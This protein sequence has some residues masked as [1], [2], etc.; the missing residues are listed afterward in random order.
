MP[1]SP[2]VRAALAA[3]C[4]LSL[5]TIAA[6]APQVPALA[7]PA[8]SDAMAL[9]RLGLEVRDDVAPH[10]VAVPA[11]AGI[12][13]DDAPGGLSGGPYVLRRLP[14]GDLF[15][16]G[17]NAWTYRGPDAL[18]LRSPRF[19]DDLGGRFG[20]ILG[21]ATSDGGFV[22]QSSQ[23]SEAL[24]GLGPALLERW[25]SPFT[26][27]EP[28]PI[29]APYTVAP[30]DHVYAFGG[31][32]SVVNGRTGAVIATIGA[33]PADE[34]VSEP[35]AAPDGGARVVTSVTETAARTL[36]R[37]ITLYRV[38]PDGTVAWSTVVAEGAGTLGVAASA[39]SVAPDGT[40]Y[41]GVATSNGI[42]RWDGRLV[43][44]GPDGAVAF[45]V[46]VGGMPSRPAIDAAGTVW[47]FTT[48]GR[49]VGVTP[50]G[51]VAFSRRLAGPGDGGSVAAHRGGVL[52]RSGALTVTMVPRPAGDAGT[53]PG[54][55]LAPSIRLQRRPFRCVAPPAGRPKTCLYRLDAALPLRI[56]APSDGT[57]D[58]TIAPVRAIL[59]D[60]GG[61]RSVPLKPARGS[62]RVL[63]GV[64]LVQLD[65]FH[66]LLSVCTPGPPCTVLP[67]D[68]R[69][70]V[71]LRAAG[72]A[73]TFARVI[74]V[75]AGTGRW[76]D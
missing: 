76:V 18:H 20:I 16:M 4:A 64:N 24:V 13:A 7:G 17:K 1:R 46:P 22:G 8:R 12:V 73:R 32:P 38:D 67:G 14:R 44:V 57:A 53:A 74:R 49:V 75:L 69:V 28:P 31:T 9:T 51:T 66:S 54:V 61:G 43:A 72:P 52:A 34:S 62:V 45:D 29:A 15:L 65:G 39:V 48:T 55:R 35:V 50:V 70:T 5:P 56:D 30:G 47:S 33:L 11:T 2:L 25:S 19:R 71:T 37:R 60:A 42:S 41:L 21:G 23:T 27:G 3:G 68:Y 59:V 40:A 58:I 10:V 63:A 6:A 26:P 36:T